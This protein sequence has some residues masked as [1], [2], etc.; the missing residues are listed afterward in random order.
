MRALPGRSPEVSLR[1]SQATGSRSRDQS[2]KPLR[3]GVGVRD[4]R[5]ASPW[6]RHR[7]PGRCLGS[8]AASDCGDSGARVTIASAVV[9]ARRPAP[10]EEGAQGGSARPLRK[11]GVGA[12][13][14][15]K[16]SVPGP[17][18]VWPG[19][20]RRRPC[21]FRPACGTCLDRGWGVR[22]GGA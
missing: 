22:G 14:L 20:A 9:M 17:H 2:P 11:P 21:G 13:G 10:G 3:R 12:R 19:S 16:G 15:G 4:K 18:K 1:L 8:A 7:T 6:C 5:L